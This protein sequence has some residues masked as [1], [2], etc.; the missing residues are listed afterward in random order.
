MVTESAHACMQ[1]LRLIGA[2]RAAGPI[3]DAAIIT[4]AGPSGLNRS[5][6][7]GEQQDRSRDMAVV[8]ILPFMAELS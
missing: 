3:K 1:V 5:L 6:T 4:T 2:R 8:A 7:E